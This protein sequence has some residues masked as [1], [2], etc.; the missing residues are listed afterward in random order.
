M[1][2]DRPVIGSEKFFFFFFF[3]FFSFFL[4]AWNVYTPSTGA[5]ATPTWKTKIKKNK[6][7]KK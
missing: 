5:A 1:E 3:F 4:G 7:N 2:K 6:K